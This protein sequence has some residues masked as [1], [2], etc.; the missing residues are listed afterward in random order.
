MYSK[1]RIVAI[2]SI[3][4]CSVSVFYAYAKPKLNLNKL[5]QYVGVK[6]DNTAQ[7]R[8]KAWRNIVDTSQG[9]TDKQKL[10]KVNRFFN[11]FDFV[12]DIDHWGKEDYWATPIEFI[13]TKAGDCEDFSVAKYFTLLELGVPI[14]KLRL[15]YVKAV[16][17][18]Q[19]H[20]VLAYYPKPKSIPMILDNIDGKIKP[21]HKRKDL[22]PI[23]SFNGQ[24][25][26]LN[27]QKGK[28]QVVGGSERIDNWDN[29]SKRYQLDEFME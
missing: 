20:M 2:T 22:I 17:L 26:W 9:L 14:E 19:F 10:E 3:I 28:G 6:Y 5:L 18:N 4:V 11:L 16:K 13:G 12:N 25:L 1:F 8:V 27:K 21:A 7:K 29:L 23:F 24:K 15:T